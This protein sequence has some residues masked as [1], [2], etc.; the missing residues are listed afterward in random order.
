MDVT[1]AAPARRWIAHA[2]QDAG[3]IAL[4]HL[5]NSHPDAI[6]KDP[7]PAGLSRPARA[8]PPRPRAGARQDF[9]DCVFDCGPGGV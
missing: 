6:A 2:A 8:A 5:D 3:K 4:P 7:Q 9:V 1:V